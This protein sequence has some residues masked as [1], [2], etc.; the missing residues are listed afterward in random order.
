MPVITDIRQQRRHP[1]RYSIYLDKRYAFS[2]SDLEL[3]SSGLRR[4]HELSDGD[5]EYWQRQSREGKAYEAA[6]RFLGYR[7]RSVR[8]IEDYL[9]RKDYEA[10]VIAG[11]IVRLQEYKFLDDRV[12]AEQWVKERQCFRPRSIRVLEQE[13]AQK[14]VSREIAR[15][16][17]AAIGETGHDQMLDDLI[18]KK[19]RQVR[20][21]DNEKLMAYLARQGFGYDQ[22]KKALTRLDD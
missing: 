8:E 10:E 1:D 4:G 5:V 9:R 7:A 2:L 19:R 22:I 18:K 20:Y 14:G 6:L 16:A 12:F 15:E 17:V 3:S 11:I 13:L 21:Q